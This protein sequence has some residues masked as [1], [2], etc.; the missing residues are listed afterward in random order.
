MESDASSDEDV[1]TTP[2]IL[3]LNCSEYNPCGRYG[4]CRDK[5]TGET[6]CLC[7]FWWNGTRCDECEKN[8]P[9]KSNS[10]A[11]FL[12][13]L[14]VSNSGQQVIALGVLVFILLVFFYGML[15]FRRIM[16]NRK[17]PKN[18]QTKKIPIFTR[19]FPTVPITVLDPSRRILSWITGILTLIVAAGTLISKWF[20]IKP[21][22]EEIVD[23]FLKNQSIFYIRPSVCRIID[24]RA[25]FNLFTFPAACLLIVLFII[26]TK[27][28]SFQRNK[29]C[30]G[31]L[32]IPIPL[33]FFGHVKRTL[34]AVIFAVFA[35]E[36][37]DIVT[38]L[39]AGNRPSSGRGVIVSYLFQII[40]VFIIGFRRYPILAAVYIDNCF[41]LACATLY[42][43]LDFGVSIVY[44]GLCRNSFY[45]TEEE[46]NK[47]H[48]TNTKINLTYYGTG[49]KLLFVQLLT[50]IPPYICLAYISVKLP[51][52]LL[53]R[54]RHRHPTDRQLTREQKD[55]LYS[56][57][58]HSAE[59]R[60]VK[61]L[62]GIIPI[63]PPKN[64]FNQILRKIYAWRDDFRFS[65][66]VVCV[67]A[68]AFLLLFFI[69]VNAYIE[70][71]PKLDAA[72]KGFQEGANF[73]AGVILPREPDV[74]YDEDTPSDFPVPNLTRAYIIGVIIALVIIIVQILVMLA[75][76][77]RNL[78]QAFR[79]NHS[80]IPGRNPSR[81]VSCIT[82]YFHFAG[83]LIGY[84][85]IGYIVLIFFA[86]LIVLVIDGFLTFGNSRLIERGLKGLIPFVLF[87]TFKLYLNK[88][89]GRIV[90]L[91]HA[92]EVL[93]VNNRRSFMVYIYFNFF[94][95]AFL[96]FIAA[97]MR[98]LKSIGGGIIY[99][100]RLDY[101]PLGRKL[102]TMDAGFNSY[103]GLIHIECAHRHPVLLCFV[104]HL[105]RD[106]L[107]PTTTKR[108][109]KAKH[110]WLL[111][112][113]LINN[114]TL[115]YQ[116]KEFL[117]SRQG[118][119]TK[120]MLIGRKN[121][122]IPYIEQPSIISTKALEDVW[123]HRR[124]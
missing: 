68:S 18:E 62:L 120:L 19:K 53:K 28:T 110:K 74:I 11:F 67:Y 33:D 119:Q 20:T 6:K 105:L 13:Y 60:Y 52:L 88:T 16:K 91:Q 121:T 98:I 112:V 50:D 44:T 25:E 99:M 92:G 57:L 59:S 7:K 24:L 4:Y 35:D 41:S 107:Y 116:R 10:H 12:L 90:F 103:C 77:R 30:K 23:K 14:V 26:I 113:F 3:R 89:L 9:C 83:Y 48:S 37:L 46:F 71:L 70:A 101:A 69:T 34:A 115:I 122:K 85:V 81:N 27:R 31:Y 38:E 29:Y 76:I 32:G 123:E 96:G 108:L 106:H 104:S 79:G 73:L 40:R 47:T 42:V 51:M 22:H 43:W 5:T 2:V 86:V 63:Q 75:S 100:C 36:L 93:S 114:P 95:D 87:T 78:I 109:S 45:L 72:Q 80:E 61:K 58:P 56:S 17:L 94:L 39:I 124:F 55:L 84:L 117:Q 118:N 97:I 15:L 8:D 102:E 64:R 111:A 54:I 65:S 49:S 21:I 66:R 1:T 82:G